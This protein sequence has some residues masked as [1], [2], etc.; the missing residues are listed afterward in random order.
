MSSPN[1]SARKMGIKT[2]CPNCAA[3]RTYS[4]AECEYCSTP[5]EDVLT[6]WS[7]RNLPENVISLPQYMA[8]ERQDNRRK[9]K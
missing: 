5:W 3:P 2:N 1:G 4:M 7:R 9:E 6:N 8:V